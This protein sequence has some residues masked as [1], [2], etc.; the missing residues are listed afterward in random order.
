VFRHRGR[1][2]QIG[3]SPSGFHFDQGADAQ[4]VIPFFSLNTAAK[5]LFQMR[6][7]VLQAFNDFNVLLRT[8]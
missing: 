4:A 5:D 3:P 8:G 6:Y 2:V 1:I 7:P